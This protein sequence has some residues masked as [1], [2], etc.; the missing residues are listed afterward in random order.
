MGERPP[1]ER[2]ANL[3]YEGF[4]ERALDPSLSANE[5]SGFPDVLRAGK[6]RR[7]LEDIASK[8]TPLEREGALVLDI[9][10]GATPLTVSLMD[11]CK[12]RLQTLF[13]V[14]SAEVLALLPGEDS[15]TNRIQRLAGR[16]PAIP[17]LQDPSAPQFDAILVYSVLQYIFADENL[18][19]FFDQC[20]RLLAPGGR[21]LIGDLPNASMRSRFLLS[22]EGTLF[23]HGYTGSSD[24]PVIRWPDLPSGQLDD[25]VIFGLAMRAR[26]AG[27]HAWILPQA[28]DLP[29]ANRREDLL[30]QRP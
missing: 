24:P 28:G 7:I 13:L 8:L 25:A 9:G 26:T 27:Y 30:C 15:A 4:Q 2:F 19:G 10:C 18:H 12:A 14:D 20:L 3:S 17:A 1:Y 5:R 21:L 23:H 29:M 22:E 16:F 11:R 6:E